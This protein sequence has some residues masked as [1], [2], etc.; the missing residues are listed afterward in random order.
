ME[1]GIWRREL[2]GGSLEEAEEEVWSRELK[3][4]S[5]E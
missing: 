5:L 3:V 1:E 4:G 2:G